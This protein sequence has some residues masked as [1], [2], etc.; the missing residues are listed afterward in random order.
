MVDFRRYPHPEDLLVLLTVARLGRFT[1]VAES[2]ETTHTT[3]SRRIQALDKQLGGRTLERSQQGWELTEL[4]RAAVAAAEAI[5][6][7]LSSLAGRL[8]NQSDPLAGLVRISASDGFG[9]KVVAP[10]LTALQHQHPLLKAE[11]LSATRRAS[12]NRSGVDLELVA[13]HVEESRFDPVFL[14]NY[15]LRLYASAG[16]LA[17]NGTPKTAAEAQSHRFV[18]YVES[19]LQIPELGH[20]AAGLSEPSAAFQS[21]GIF[22]QMESVRHDGG[23]GILPSFMVF[24]DPDFVPVLPDVFERKLQFWAV[25]RPESLRSSAVQSVIAALISETQK[26]AVALAS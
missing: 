14:S 24:G 11:L 7:S 13:G 8:G 22:S 12:Q 2:L 21:T 19:A 16:Y 3:I 5:E 17:R 23:I 10:A 25:A 4:G 9:A 6:S 18:S 20:R 15:Y 1:A 26:Q